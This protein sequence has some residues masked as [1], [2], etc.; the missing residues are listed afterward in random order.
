MGD[1]I[2]SKWLTGNV[3]KRKA[4]SIKEKSLTKKKKRMKNERENNEK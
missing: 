2:V 3:S 4:A 1:S